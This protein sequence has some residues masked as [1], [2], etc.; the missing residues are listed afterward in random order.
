MRALR[1]LEVVGESL[2]ALL[3]P[4]I[5]AGTMLL[6]ARR[7][8]V[9][10]ALIA[11]AMF[12]GYAIYVGGDAFEGL[13]RVDRF[14][15]FALPLL[16]LAAAA[17]I[18]PLVA[19]LEQSLAGRLGILALPIVLAGALL[20]AVNENGL[21]SR[22]AWSSYLMDDLPPFVTRQARILD[23]LDRLQTW[24]SPPA[25]VATHWA[26][27]P[28]YFSDYRLIDIL[29]YNDR[30][31]ARLPP[32]TTFTRANYRDYLPGHEKWDYNEVF[33]RRPDAFFSVWGL[34]PD[35]TE[36]L[37]VEHNYVKHDDFWLAAHSPAVNLT[38]TPR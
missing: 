16:F 22:P 26:G 18:D 6:S 4:L 20:L 31:I 14:L 2:L 11:F 38:S 35:Q 5:L 1:G 7:R 32:N 25:L 17:A 8:A 15:N 19:R 24:V 13:T 10:I 30:V 23:R 29:G 28:G 9:A 12:A 36:R 21:A 27:Y 3:L 33:A 34:S 37:M